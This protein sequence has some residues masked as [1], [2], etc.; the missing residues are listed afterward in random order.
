MKIRG[1][2]QTDITQGGK[3]TS[4]ADKFYMET[5]KKQFNGL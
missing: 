5:M 4:T 3:K 2:N 1:T